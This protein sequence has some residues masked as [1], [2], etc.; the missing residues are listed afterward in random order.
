MYIFA[1]RERFYFLDKTIKKH[2]YETSF[3]NLRDT[4]NYI[5]VSHKGKSIAR[6]NLPVIYMRFGNN[7]NVFTK[8][9]LFLIFFAIEYLVIV[10][11]NFNL[12][13]NTRGKKMPLNEI[14]YCFKFI[15]MF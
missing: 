5:T 11:C 6:N 7:L 12:M 1:L 15:Y 3:L 9:C 8:I 2:V 13:E 10:D 4:M 14:E